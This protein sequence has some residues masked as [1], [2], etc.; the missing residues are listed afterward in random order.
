[1][2]SSSALMR[3]MNIHFQ[4]LLDLQKTQLSRLEGVTRQ[5]RLSD[6]NF[7]PFCLS[8]SPECTYTVLGY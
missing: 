5:T 6:R 3:C 4:L 8:M 2:L 7:K 1:M